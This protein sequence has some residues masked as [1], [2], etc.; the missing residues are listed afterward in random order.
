MNRER[1]IAIEGIR[2]QIGEASSSMKK[3]IDKEQAALDNTPETLQE[4]DRYTAAADA[5]EILEAALEHLEE[6]FDSLA[7]IV[8]AGN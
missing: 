7:D 5:M 3:I 4:T 6:A 1:R 2:Q 8:Q